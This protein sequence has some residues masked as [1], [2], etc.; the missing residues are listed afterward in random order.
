M[1]KVAHTSK[2]QKKVPM[3]VADGPPLGARTQ[4]DTRMEIYIY[5]NMYTYENLDNIECKYPDLYVYIC[6]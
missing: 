2:L 4:R 1:H 3:G 5:S 6:K